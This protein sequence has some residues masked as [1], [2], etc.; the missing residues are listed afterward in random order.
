MGYASV[1][2][3]LDGSVHVLVHGKDPHPFPV[4]GCSSCEG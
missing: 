1:L 3:T 4:K 2:P